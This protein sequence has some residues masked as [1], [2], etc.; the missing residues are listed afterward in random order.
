LARTDLLAD[1]DVVPELLQLAVHGRSNLELAE[2]AGQ[3]VVARLGL[4]DGGLLRRELALFRLVETGEPS[5]GR[6]NR[7]V[8]ASSRLF[9]LDDDLTDQTSAKSF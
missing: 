1:L 8:A 9:R 6:L 5:F 2:V 4:A 3:R 7:L